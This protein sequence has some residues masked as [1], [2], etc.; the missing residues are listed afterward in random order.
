MP[1]ELLRDV[2][3]PGDA[4]GRARRRAFMLPASIAAH[5]LAVAAIVIIPLAA[6]VE[7]PPPMSPPLLVRWV[8]T[9]PPP[10][11]AYRPPAATVPTSA[12]PREA[13]PSIAP[14]TDRPLPP[15]NE[16]VPPGALL[17]D[18]GAVPPG[19]GVLGPEVGTPPPPPPPPVQ[20]PTGPIRIT[21]GLKP[22][23][24]V[25]HVDPV[26]PVMARQAHIEGV[27]IVEATIDE[28]GRIDR[29]KVLRS[30]PLLD[31]AAL[32]AVRRWRYTPTLLNGVPVPVLLTITVSFKLN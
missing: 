32:E 15:T 27:V 25:F 30:A 24:K 28:T 7:L 11:P 3:R 21:N 6:D 2:L 22:P 26:Y 8:A 4:P 10:P 16:P 13:P 20:R 14:E 17:Y 31:A 5:T 23:A 29:L 9:T 1:Q 18:G 19:V 12:A